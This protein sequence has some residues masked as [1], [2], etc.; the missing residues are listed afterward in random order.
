MQIIKS[1]LFQKFPEIIFGLSTKNGMDRNL[2]FSFNLSLTVGDNSDIVNEN[3]EA[4]YNKLGLKTEQ[5]AIQKQIHSDIITVVEKPGLIGESDAMITTKP[6]IGLAISTA[7]CV[8][9]FVYDRMN[10]IIAGIHSG[11]R[12]TQKQIL[13]KTLKFLSESFNSKS[14]YLFTYIGPSISQNNY[15]VGEDVALQFDK[16]YSCMKNGKIFLDVS[17]TNLD[18]IYNFGIPK[19]N[20]EISPF[21]SFEEKELLHSYRRDGKLSGRSFGVI[22][23][24]EI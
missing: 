6:N 3:R 15:E 14:E 13:Q 8:P 7:D 24:R 19:K 16:K 4:F 21:C 10:K 9:I 12:G 20:I 11:W 18:M 17:R 1:H 23:M 5:I 2:P 22:A